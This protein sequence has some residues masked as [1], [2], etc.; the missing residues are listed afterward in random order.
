MSDEQLR[1]A[2]EHIVG[3]DAPGHLDRQALPSVLVYHGQ[4]PQGPAVVGSGRHQIVG[5]DVITVGR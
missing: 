2:G 3:P 5:P 1:E 4:Q